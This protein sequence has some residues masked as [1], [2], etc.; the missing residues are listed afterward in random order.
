[1]VRNLFIKIV[2]MNNFK[3]Y[4]FIMWSFVLMRS[5]MLMCSFV[6]LQLQMACQTQNPTFQVSKRNTQKIMQIMAKTSFFG[7]E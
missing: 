5:F 7:E 4:Y 3:N 6:E 2:S 1:M